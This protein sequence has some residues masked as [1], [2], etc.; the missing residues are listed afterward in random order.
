MFNFYRG[1]AYHP[2]CISLDEH[3]LT[4]TNQ[5]CLDEIPQEQLEY[6]NH[7]FWATL[8]LVP[9]L[10]NYLAGWYRWY[11]EDEKRQYTWPACLVGFYPLLRE[12]SVIRELWRNPKRGLAKKRKFEREMSEAEVFYESIP[13]CVILSYILHNIAKSGNK[14]R[15]GNMVVLN[16]N[17]GSWYFSFTYYPSIISA[18]LGMAKVLKV[19]FSE[20]TNSWNFYNI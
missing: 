10:L 2:S 12:A 9:F 5:T 11:Q 17:F 18:S 14:I 20:N 4:I 13:T 8:L 6:E 7:P 19:R 3:N 15:G 1:Y 16:S